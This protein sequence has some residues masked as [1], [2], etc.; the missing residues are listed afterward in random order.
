MNVSTVVLGEM[1][2]NLWSRLDFSQVLIVEKRRPQLLKLSLD[3]KKVIK[4]L[5]SLDYL[6]VHDNCVFM[7]NLIV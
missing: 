3:F 4:V 6:P 5:F 2:H 7:C 1:G